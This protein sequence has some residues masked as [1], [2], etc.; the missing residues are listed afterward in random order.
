M[1]EKEV[2]NTTNDV[3]LQGSIVHK[4]STPAV[5]ILTLA[6]KTSPTIVNYPKVTFFGEAKNKADQFEKGDI[7]KV[8]GNIQSSKVNPKIKNQV[9]LAVFGEDVTGAKTV[10]EEAFNVEGRYVPHKNEFKIAGTVTSVV[11]VTPEVLAVTVRTDKN[12]RPSFVRLT[13]FVGAKNGTDRVSEVAPGDF[14]YAV[15][16]VQTHKSAKSGETKYF[17]NYVVSEFKK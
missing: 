3:V 5:T 4:F 1:S 9:T 7:V 10:M 6:V 2:K 11:A 17:Q 15:G 13:R 14:I 16:H 12:K 8:D